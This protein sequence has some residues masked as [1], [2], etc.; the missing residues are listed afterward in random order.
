MIL[1]VF[2]SIGPDILGVAT[3]MRFTGEVVEDG[4][5]KIEGK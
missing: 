2:F 4:R 1:L 5:I 3:V